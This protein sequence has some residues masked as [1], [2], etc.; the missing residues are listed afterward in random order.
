MSSADNPVEPENLIAAALDAAEEI[1]D[2]LD[3][4]TEKTATD[5]DAPF[6]P[7]ALARLAALKQDDRAAFEALRAKLKKAG[8]RGTALDESIAE[9]NGEMGGR[10]VRRRPTS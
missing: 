5:P 9:E 7:D 3:G 10:A 1:R 4:L 6:E 2:A 8:C